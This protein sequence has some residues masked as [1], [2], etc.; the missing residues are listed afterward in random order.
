VPG[1]IDI[2]KHPWQRNTLLIF[3][4]EGTGLTPAM[5]DLCEVIVEIPMFGSVRSLNCGTASGIVMYD[6]VATFNAFKDGF[7]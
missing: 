7:L 5:Q 6:I 4:E 2:S 1:S 3:G